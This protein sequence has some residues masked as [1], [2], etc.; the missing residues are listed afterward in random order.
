LKKD[1]EH[2]N[3]PPHAHFGNVSSIFDFLHSSTTTLNISPTN[4]PVSLT[5]QGRS[6]NYKAAI[7]HLTMAFFLLLLPVTFPFTFGASLPAANTLAHR[8]L[9]KGHTVEPLHVNG[10][11]A[12]IPFEGYGT[13]QEIYA[14]FQRDHPDVVYD[15]MA[16]ALDARSSLESR[17][18]VSRVIRIHSTSKFDAERI[19]LILN[20]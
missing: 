10:T 3:H 4:N 11:I 12:G 20:F 19:M 6:N 2:I 1:L 18:T 14:Q 16:G 13:V 9:P 17:S 5:L 15:P 8:D 7:M